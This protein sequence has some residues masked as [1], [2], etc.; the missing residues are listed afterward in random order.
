METLRALADAG[1]TLFGIGQNAFQHSHGLQWA[2]I[3]YYLQVRQVHFD[4]L[5]NMREDVRDLY[6]M[7]ARKIDTIMIVTVLM[8]SVGFGFVVEG[9]FPSQEPEVTSFNTTSEYWEH[10]NMYRG[11]H[12]WRLIYAI[13][14]GLA[15]VNPFVSIVCLL[16]VKR[17]LDLFMGDFSHVFNDL[18]QRFYRNFQ[19]DT[20][21]M[22]MM[23]RSPLVR[24][25]EGLPG[26]AFPTPV[27]LF[28][29]LGAEARSI[30]WLRCFRRKDHVRHCPPRRQLGPP[31]LITENSVDPGSF[32]KILGLHEQYVIWWENNC[33][34]YYTAGVVFLWLGVIANVASCAVLLGMYFQFNYPDVPWMWRSYVLVV[35]LGSSLAL[36]CTARG[37][38]RSVLSEQLLAGSPGHLT[39]GADV[40]NL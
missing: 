33:S 27:Q 34:R 9:T 25:T 30:P 2:E 36:V 26:E 28:Q 29:G 17:R 1:L 35:V 16:E 40:S 15:L 23:H 21:S 8:L 3:D 24:H 32:E 6:E 20:R 13:A 18:L 7:D 12:I 10:E 5:N 31:L 11:Q 39:R 14:A 4:M 22:D 19:R 37:P 38:T